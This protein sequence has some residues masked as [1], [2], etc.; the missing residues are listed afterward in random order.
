MGTG[1]HGAIEVKKDGKWEFTEKLP[2]GRNYGAFAVLFDVQNTLE[3][4]S[5]AGGRGLPNDMDEHSTFNWIDKLSEAERDE[6]WKKRQL[7]QSAGSSDS[8]SH[9]WVTAK[10]IFDS[11]DKEVT[12]ISIY[13]FGWSEKARQ[14]Y[15][16]L[17]ADLTESRNEAMKREPDK[18]WEPVERYIGT[19]EEYIKQSPAIA[20]FVKGA[21]IHYG[22]GDVNVELELLAHLYKKQGK[23]FKKHQKTDD[24]VALAKTMPD[25]YEVVE[26][27]MQ[28]RHINKWL[29][30]KAY[31]A[32]V[33]NKLKHLAEIY[34]AENVR[35]VVWFDN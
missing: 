29:E 16:E 25:K 32:L 13:K 26:E 30:D 17:H 12:F 20:C 24:V 1:I 5:V 2:V 14:H 34:G 10:E 6:L 23:K 8:H 18:E 3:V 33:N 4:P 9:T 28:M 15:R 35:C 7:E 21:H 22:W 11:L 19:E 31:D 27:A